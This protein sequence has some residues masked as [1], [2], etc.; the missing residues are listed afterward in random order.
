MGG[1]RLAT[2]PRGEHETQDDQEQT[3]AGDHGEEPPDSWQ[4]DAFDDERE[5]GD[6]RGEEA[7]DRHHGSYP[8]NQITPHP[9]QPNRSG[10]VTLPLVR[11]DRAAWSAST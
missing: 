9:R 6:D 1:N 7:D 11:G 10:Q 8:Q 5:D 4:L 3:H 2:F